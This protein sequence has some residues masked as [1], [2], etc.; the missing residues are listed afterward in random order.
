MKKIILI[1][2][3]LATTGIYSQ[4]SDIIEITTSASG[5][6]KEV[7][8][9]DALRSALEQ[10]YGSFISTKTNIK[11]DELLKD[12]IVAI[13]SGEIHDY[14]LVSETKIESGYAVTIVAKISKSVLN[15]FVT[16]SGGDAI[17][18]DANVFSTKIRLQ[19]LN[20]EAEIKSINNL[21]EVLEEIYAR[22]I[23]FEFTSSN[24]KINERNKKWRVDFEIITKYNENILNFIDY[25]S[26]SLEKIAMTKKQKLSYKELG[27]TTYPILVNND[28]YYFRNEASYTAINNFLLRLRNI[29]S[30]VKITTNNGRE[31]A[32]Y[33]GLK[34]HRNYYKNFFIPYL[35]HSAYGYGGYNIGYLGENG[36]ISKSSY[37][38][39]RY[40]FIYS[41][42]LKGKLKFDEFGIPETESSSSVL[43]LNKDNRF[44][45]EKNEEYDGQEIWIGEIK[46]DG[47]NIAAGGERLYMK[48]IIDFNF[49]FSLNNLD[50]IY[51]N[52]NEIGIDKY[53]SQ[54]NLTKPIYYT[55]TF[56]GGGI[57][58][59][60]A[61]RYSETENIIDINDLKVSKKRMNRIQKRIAK[62]KLNKTEIKLKLKKLMS[63]V[64]TKVNNNYN[65][66]KD[67]THSAKFGFSLEFTED[68][69]FSNTGYKL[70]N[71]ARIN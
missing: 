18:F 17:I 25:F 37:K 12:E 48:N 68:E 52:G 3:I 30:K 42:G 7:A 55:R 36:E 63:S 46:G 6:T 27:K 49:S 21:L 54:N 60:Y 22:S 38:S 53:L 8:I 70:V 34:K 65:G 10:S 66:S 44:F 35:N 11:N 39:E 51:I 19:K 67:L 45:I 23:E 24:P 9:Q 14:E 40:Q 13:T 59:K 20:E 61:I 41:F 5:I 4:N 29:F 47:G 43:M 57:E 28:F 58:G 31:I 71:E 32:N 50:N 64:S 1:I 26:S 16:Q 15:N 2:T 69:M 62:T 33:G 56:I